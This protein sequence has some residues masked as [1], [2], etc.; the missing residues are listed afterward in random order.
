MK[1]RRLNRI[2]RWLRAGFSRVIDAIKPR[3]GVD[4]RVRS[5]L[6]LAGFDVLDG[7][8]LGSQY[9]RF[10]GAVFCFHINDW[11]R[12]LIRSWMSP[13]KLVFVPFKESEADLVSGWLA[14]IES[15]P[16]STALVWGM[17]L[18]AIAAE[19]FRL[20][21]VP[22]SYV[23]D[24]FIRSV[25]LGSDRALPLSLNF[26]TRAP[27]FDAS[28][29][30]DLEVLLSSY[31]FKS[32][33]RLMARASECMRKIIY[34]G[35]SKY[36]PVCRGEIGKILGPRSEKRVLVVGQVEDDASI[37]HGSSIRY[38]NNDV[39]MLAKMEHP[40]ARI[41]YRPHPDVASG[42]RKMISNPEDVEHLC[43]VLWDD[44]SLPDL[45]GEVDHVYTITSQAGFEAAMRGIPVT[46]LGCPFYAGWGITDDRQPCLRR[47][48]KLS[49]EEVFA[50]SYILYPQYFDFLSRRRVD[51]E[52][53]LDLLTKIR[54]SGEKIA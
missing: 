4:A 53:V 37:V 33:H 14:A 27:Y 9:A 28:R 54:E 15:I 26:D 47:G 40:D 5:A 43:C 24:G 2:K 18:P 29:P 1:N 49:V 21:G 12:D 10:E 36:N 22:L 17:K 51:L 11:K 25:G 38:T 46:V 44:V 16:S 30:S 50:A 31:D 52:F 42:N 19:F 23:E 45:L 39:V 32:D 6:R 8:P 7:V 35:L 34:G 41:F 3:T 13:C 48:R 20:K